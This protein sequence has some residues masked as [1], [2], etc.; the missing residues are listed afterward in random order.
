MN[1][2]IHEYVRRVSAVSVVLLLAAC[3]QQDETTTGVSGADKV[4]VTT[5]SAR[6]L[7]LYMEGR[8]LLDDLHFTE[9]HEIFLEAVDEDP[10]FAMGH[11]MVASTS[12]TAA[13]F[14]DAI[15]AADARAHNATAGEQLFIAALFAASE[16]D[17]GAQHEALDEL[18]AMYPNDERTHMALGNFLNGQQDFAGAAEHFAHATEV[19][20]EFAP[21]FNALGYAKRSLED[22]DG[23]KAAF[24]TYVALIPGEANPHD[25]Y[26]ELLMEM[27]EYEKSIEHYRKSLSID[28]NFAASYAGIAI[29]ESL[30][31]RPDLAQEASDQMLAAARNFAERQAAMFQSVT[32][33][34]FAGNSDAAMEVCATML[35][36]A[37]VAGNHSAMGGVY[38]YMGDA[39]MVAGDAAAAEAHFKAALEHRQQ[40]NINDANKAQ[41]RRTHLFKTAIAAMIGDD[42]EAATARAAEYTAAAEA[43][44]TAFERRR[45]HELGGYLAMMNEDMQAAAE[46]LAQASQLDP[47][48]LYW[49]AVVNAE[50][51]NTDKA[52]ELAE[53]AAN[54]NTLSANLPFFRA[55]ALELV[56]N[57]EAG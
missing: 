8:A 3:G 19:N 30:R 37:E 14:F 35:A 22:F 41:A 49:S 26:A 6:A 34:L 52:R 36:E 12:P 48:V 42:A 32:A 39:M 47:I 20:N 27:G 25:S 28:P 43:K 29:N 51:G 15:A 1:T 45:I 11:F 53:R 56:A 24:E 38:E 17:Q 55:D 21:A 5:S 46:L 23:A 31:G 44:G 50:L 9:A 13:E 4:A 18:V 33:H 40:A 2:L 16:N 57:L 10:E 7:D 54:R